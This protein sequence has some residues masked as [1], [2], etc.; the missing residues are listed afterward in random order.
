MH[1]RLNRRTTHPEALLI[2]GCL[3]TSACTTGNESPESHDVAF[4]HAAAGRPLAAVRGAASVVTRSAMPAVAAGP[5]SASPNSAVQVTPGNADAG[6][7]AALGSAGVHVT[8]RVGAANAITVQALANALCTIHR[9]DATSTDGVTVT[10]DDD[11]VGVF[12]FTPS[13]DGVSNTM[14]LDCQDANGVTAR[15]SVDVLA[16]AAAPLLT[17]P[18][19]KGRVRPP[20]SGD[21]K[22]PSQDELRAMNFPPRPDP[23]SR[24]QAYATWL[25]SVTKPMTLVS[26]K[27]VPNPK[28]RHTVL[29]TY[30]VTGPNWAGYAVSP[31]NPTDAAPPSAD[32]GLLGSYGL[33]NVPEVVGFDNV[34]TNVLAMWNGVGGFGASGPGL[35]QVTGGDL[36]Q[37]GVEI[38]TKAHGSGYVASY[39]PWVEYIAGPVALPMA[40]LP[41]TVAASDQVI[42]WNYFGGYGTAAAPGY[43]GTTGNP[44]TQYVWYFLEDGTQN[45]STGFTDTYD[46]DGT[47]QNAPIGQEFSDYQTK[48][49]GTSI[50]MNITGGSA[51]WVVERTDFYP[52]QPGYVNLGFTPKCLFVGLPVPV[53]IPTGYA[54]PFVQFENFVMDEPAVTTYGLAGD[55]TVPYSTPAVYLWQVT[56]AGLDGGTLAT[57][58]ISGTGDQ[59]QISFQWKGY[60]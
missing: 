35:P 17:P 41:Y 22:A 26:S 23:V 51:E 1:H 45:W 14:V 16:D 21:P 38:Q 42:F 59:A 50:T 27:P 55:D 25:R 8:A 60:N 56:M 47:S 40:T 32:T 48:H 49:P 10:T 58:S 12:F 6:L 43:P 31:Q 44:S 20:L 39:T 13:T 28:G 3:I 37:G 18:A 52:Y 29:N 7:S 9:P 36:W 2:A 24:P 34:T 15:T 53:C 57:S 54:A 46:P 4:G 5:A 11:G 33:W 19:P 30:G